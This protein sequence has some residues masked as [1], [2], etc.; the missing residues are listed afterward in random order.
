M[1]ALSFIDNIKMKNKIIAMCAIVIIPVFFAG[2][3]L[4]LSIINIQKNNAINEGFNNADRLQTRLNDMVYT[5][6]NVE[7]KI[8]QNRDIISIIEIDTN[9]TDNIKQFNQKSKTLN[10]YLTAYTQISGIQ[11][12]LDTDEFNFNS[13]FIKADD[14]IKNTY[15]YKSAIESDGNVIWDVV[16]NPADNNTYLS[17]IRALYSQT[18]ELKGV[19]V[20]Y[21]NPEWLDELMKKESVNAIFSVKDCKIFYSNIDKYSI[22]SVVCYPDLASDHTLN[23]R[24]YDDK[25]TLVDNTYT[26]VESFE[27]ENTGNMFQIFLVKPI[28]NITS[29]TQN[30]TRV[31]IWYMICC[32]LL[33]LLFSFLL[34]SIF[35]RRV[36]YLKNQMH[37]VAE[38]DFSMSY[39]ISGNDEITEL[40][41]DLETMVNSM[42][43]LINE[44]FEARLMTET[45]KLNQVEA[46]FKALSSQ[47]NPHF[48]Y[49][50]LETIRMKAYCSNDKETAD[51]IK[52]LGKFM[53]RCLEVK[54]SLVTIKSELD[55][56]KSYLE[57][58]GA[59]FGDRVS[60]TIDCNVD[61]DYSILPLIIQPIVEN[62]FIH[63]IEDCKQN[64]RID[65]TVVY[66]NDDVVITVKDNGVGI[67]EEKMYELK[68]KL[69]GNDT[70]SGKSIGL[71]N[72]NK[73]IKLYHG[74]K[75]GLSI[76]SILGQGTTVTILLPK[77]SQKN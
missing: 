29:N 56:T 31:Y 64:G 39:K 1:K 46:E 54:D 47:I 10:D 61:D 15:W 60:Y 66:N 55:F 68:K 23:L 28:S 20:I 43:N 12:Y 25:S 16:N 70:S 59:R 62:A 34:A 74:E 9:D 50:T 2:V 49:N 76:S 37:N 57:L 63:G 35:S 5:T 7:E 3:F 38:G 26:I 67:T 51:L 27:Y 19:M 48:L 77:N 8:Y 32:F 71:T 17:L 11:F 22:G 14:D 30:I 65:I 52:K 18:G 4:L 53:R 41:K 40:N 45:L 72:V 13:Q 24:T 36:Q 21:I 69:E 42:K 6:M 33:S 75:Y 73:R 58:Q 44:A